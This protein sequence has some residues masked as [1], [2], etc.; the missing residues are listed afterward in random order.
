MQIEYLEANSASYTDL[1]ATSVAVSK[2]KKCPSTQ[3][4]QDV[5]NDKAS[6]L[7]FNNWYKA[8]FKVAT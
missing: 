3:V 2:Q 6:Q 7:H 1:E 5:F 4:V 8:A